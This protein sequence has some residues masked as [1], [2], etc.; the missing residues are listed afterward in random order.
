VVGWLLVCGSGWAAVKFE[1][2]QGRSNHRFRTRR[3]VPVVP[4]LSGSVYA[5]GSHVIPKKYKQSA[6]IYIIHTIDTYEEHKKRFQ[7]LTPFKPEIRT[8]YAFERPLGDVIHN[9]RF[10]FAWKEGCLTG[11]YNSLEEATTSLASRKTRETHL[12]PNCDIP[13]LAPLVPMATSDWTDASL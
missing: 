8:W 9:K 5:K 7:Y 2:L 3:T 4:Q 1:S 12:I 11:T 13:F 10:F 6:R